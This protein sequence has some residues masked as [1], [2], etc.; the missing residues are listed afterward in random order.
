[1][2]SEQPHVPVSV[3]KPDWHNY[4]RDQIQIAE[5]RLSTKFEQ[6]SSNDLK[7]LELKL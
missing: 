6:Q 2:V 7:L 1:M 4:L 3:V 5:T